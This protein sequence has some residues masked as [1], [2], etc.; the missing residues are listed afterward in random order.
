MVNRQQNRN[1]ILHKYY[2]RTQNIK[3]ILWDSKILLFFLM[4]DSAKQENLSKKLW[5]L[6][7]R[8]NIL[9]FL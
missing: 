3:N 8:T 1:N 7:L 5:K 6:Y 2:T 9:F 4:N